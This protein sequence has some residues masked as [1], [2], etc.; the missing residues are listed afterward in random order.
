[1]SLN[2]FVNEA[3]ATGTEEKKEKKNLESESNNRIPP[4]ERFQGGI[5]TNAITRIQQ[6]SG[7]KEPKKNGRI[8]I[9]QQHPKKKKLENS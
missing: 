3:E 1:M 4:K 7:L 6:T 8:G 5:A 2:T 9:A